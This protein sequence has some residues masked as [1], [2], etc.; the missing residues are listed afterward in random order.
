[1]IEY[2]KFHLDAENRKSGKYL[3]VLHPNY[4]E[5]G[6]SGKIWK[7]EDFFNIKLDDSI[8]EIEEY[9]CILLSDKARLSKYVLLN[10]TTQVRTNRSSIWVLYNGDWK[11]IFHQGTRRE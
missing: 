6:E 7:K 5:F 10:K 8:Y 4:E 2:E 11:M 9:K 1:M 3:E